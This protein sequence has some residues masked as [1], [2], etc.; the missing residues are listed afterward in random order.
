MKGLLASLLVLLLAAACSPR[1]EQREL[2]LDPDAETLPTEPSEEALSAWNLRLDDPLGESPGFQL[3]VEGEALA[4][5]TGPAG[6]VW[7][8]VDLVLEGDFRAGATFEQPGAAARG[9]EAYGLI[10][11]GRNLPDPDQAYTFFLIRPTGEYMIARRE[12]E[13]VRM[14]VNWT[15][16]PPAPSQEGE[17]APASHKLAVELG[18]E[19]VRFLVDGQLVHTLPRDEVE[20]YGLAGLRVNGELELRVTEWEMSGATPGEMSR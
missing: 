9:D 13:E 11:G 19:E 2:E 10:V 20:P 6:I 15:S 12:G 3:V 4:V 8:P 1:E 5:S 17:A 7:R 14:L 16:G 18:G